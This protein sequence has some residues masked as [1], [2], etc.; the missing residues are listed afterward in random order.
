MGPDVAAEIRREVQHLLN[1][2]K[3]RGFPGAQPVSFDRRS[4]QDIQS[5]DFYVCE[6][7]DGVRCLM[8][9]TREPGSP[10]PDGGES[11]IETAYMWDRR[12]D[13]YQVRG[14]HFPLPGDHERFWFN[15]VLDGELVNDLEPDGSIV[16]RFVA[17]DLLVLDTKLLTDRTLDK[18]LAYLKESIY[19]PYDKLFKQYPDDL[20]NLPFQFRMKDMQLGYAMEMMF[21]DVLPRLKH[22]NDGLIFTCRTTPYT[23]G[24][25]QNI[26]KW[27]PPHEN[28][29]DFKIRL[30]I[31]Q[32][33]P[34]DGDAPFPDYEAI[35]RIILLIR[36]DR[37]EDIPRGE[38]YVTQE[39]WANLVAL[40]E[41]LDDRIVEAR[42]DEQKRW[43]YM[44]FRDDKA[45][46]NHASVFDSVFDS[47]TDAITEQD[48][49]NVAGNVKR[50]WK[51]RNEPAM[52]R[53]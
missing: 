40:N 16:M 49:V 14:H 43:R 44:R 51:A 33:Q 28:S 39:E 3:H 8:Y 36:A 29:I 18:R 19:N 2:T 15:S 46:A 21:R 5:R 42:L 4:M 41:P 12:D 24:T 23:I 22:G 10:R 27:K 53:P 37:N 17:F 48:L 25:D 11:W 45:N 30:D 35:P 1:V 6:K 20:R 47:I 9:L 50:A 31:P 26:I 7:S 34:E 52:Q 38:L 32:Y 13:F